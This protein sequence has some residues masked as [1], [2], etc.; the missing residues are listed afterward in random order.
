MHAARLHLPVVME[1]RTDQERVPGPL[2][3][4]PLGVRSGRP[5]TPHATFGPSALVDDS[6]PKSPDSSSPEV[7]GT[8]FCRNDWTGSRFSLV[9][10]DL[11][12]LATHRLASA[13][14]GQTIA[15]TELVHE[16]FAR[17]VKAEDRTWENRRHFIDAAGVAMRCILVDR[18][19]ARNRLKRRADG[20]RVDLGELAAS[21]FAEDDERIERVDAALTRLEQI[22]RRAAG[23]VTMKFFLGLEEEEIASTLGVTPRTVRRDWAYAKAW[24]K[25]EIEE[26]TDGDVT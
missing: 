2:Q 25:A 26:P 13:P 22:D 11:R 14:A 16:V 10:E 18:A 20:L 6:N 19:R 3:C 9:Y 1:D 24:L 8:A 17:L 15:P 23:V 12:R 5:L 7:A 4:V 21:P